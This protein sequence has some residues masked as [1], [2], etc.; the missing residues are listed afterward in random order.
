MNSVE[1]LETLI[2][3]DTTSRRSNLDLVHAIQAQLAPY[4]TLSTRV[5]YD[6][7]K[8]KSNLFITIPAADGNFKKDGLILSG[9]MDVVPVDRQAWASDP[10]KAVVTADR[11]Y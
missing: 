1:W 10:F 11:V 2:S 6:T 4:S 8:E 5:T 3:F 7:S 9:H